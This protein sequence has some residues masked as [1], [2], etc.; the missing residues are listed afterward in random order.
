MYDPLQDSTI[1]LVCTALNMRNVGIG[2]GWTKNGALLRLEPGQEV[3]EDLYPEGS[4][5]TVSSVKKTAV[6]TCNVA[7]RSASVQI[8]VIDSSLVPL[9][10]PESLWNREWP[11]AAAGSKAVLPCPRGFVGRHVTRKCTMRSSNFSEWEIPDFEGCL[12]EPL[13]D[14]YDQVRIFDSFCI[15]VNI[16]TV[17]V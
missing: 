10:Q 1:R 7:H 4:L 2:F 5:L 15:N 6:Y 14:P 9:C 12:Y 13:Q 11:M 17:Y 3:W 16:I 8:N